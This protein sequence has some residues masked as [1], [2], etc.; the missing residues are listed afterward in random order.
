MRIFDGCR[1]ATDTPTIE[2]GRRSPATTFIAEPTTLRIQPAGI[3]LGLQRFGA[4][5]LCSCSTRLI[6]LARAAEH[7]MQEQPLVATTGRVR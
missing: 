3:C 4:S 1:G 2:F 6:K 7:N 5:E